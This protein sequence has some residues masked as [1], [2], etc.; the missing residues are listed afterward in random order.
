MVELNFDTLVQYEPTFFKHISF[1]GKGFGEGCVLKADRY[2]FIIHTNHIY[3]GASWVDH[4][5]QSQRDTILNKIYNKLGLVRSYSWGIVEP[6]RKYPMY[7]KPWVIRT[8]NL[9]LIL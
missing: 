2:Y 1:E 5:I 4:T 7:V 9:I 8:S 3:D 6:P